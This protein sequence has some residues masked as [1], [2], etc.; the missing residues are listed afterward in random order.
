MPTVR[1]QDAN[2]QVHWKKGD[3]AVDENVTR[4]NLAMFKNCSY[5][6]GW[7]PTRFP[8][9][10]DRR[11][12]LVHIDVDLHQPTHDTLEF[13]YERMNP[14]GVMI[15][16]DYGSAQCPGAKKAVDDFFVGK[17]NAFFIPTGQ[18]F[19]IKR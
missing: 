9:V 14:G 8:E 2:N 16:D 15:C 5:Y 1:D 17:E 18:A 10:A 7:V 3:I 13:F 12:A 4:H 6:K 11:F 19:I